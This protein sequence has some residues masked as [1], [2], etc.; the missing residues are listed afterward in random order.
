M[1]PR[2]PLSHRACRRG[3]RDDGGQ[4]RTEKEGGLTTAASMSNPTRW[5]GSTWTQ[6]ERI[7]LDTTGKDQPGHNWKGS[8]RP[9][10]LIT[11]FV[12]CV[13]AFGRHGP[14]IPRMHRS[15]VVVVF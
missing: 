15:L 13:T 11:A 2:F 8:T 6:L 1:K 9:F 3:K 7:N 14:K 12:T 4:R 10:T 5:K